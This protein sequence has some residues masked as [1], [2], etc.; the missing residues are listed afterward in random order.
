VAGV[1]ACHSRS[2][3]GHMF[4]TFCSM[5]VLPKQEVDSQI[6]MVSAA[7]FIVFIG[8]NSYTRIVEHLPS[9]FSECHV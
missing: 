8:A 1:P 4:G 3:Y 6:V 5:R 7:V 9:H 2:L